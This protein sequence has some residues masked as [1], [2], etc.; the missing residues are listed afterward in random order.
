MKSAILFIIAFICGFIFVLRLQPEKKS[1][2]NTDKA[3]ALGVLGLK[4]NASREQITNTYYN[5][6]RIHH[7]DFGGNEFIAARLNWAK[8]VLIGK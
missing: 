2:T 4:M 3:E 5:L 7:P 8:D 6:M 1:F